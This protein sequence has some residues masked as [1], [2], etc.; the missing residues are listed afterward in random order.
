[1]RFIKS[2]KAKSLL[3]K[4]YTNFIL[5]DHKPQFHCLTWSE[6]WSEKSHIAQLDLERI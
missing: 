5:L 1:M 3:Y 6:S 2:C 4:I